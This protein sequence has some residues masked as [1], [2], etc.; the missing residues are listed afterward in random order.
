MPLQPLLRLEAAGADRSATDH[1]AAALSSARDRFAVSKAWLPLLWGR[2]SQSH[3]CHSDRDTPYVQHRVDTFIAG[4]IGTDT[5]GNCQNVLSGLP[6]D[7]TNRQAGFV[8]YQGLLFFA[9]QIIPSVSRFFMSRV[10]RIHMVY[11][12][13]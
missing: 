1:V 10:Y 7:E 13:K 8:C 12:V 9:I 5:P 2:P 11:T 4:H 6:K 3:S